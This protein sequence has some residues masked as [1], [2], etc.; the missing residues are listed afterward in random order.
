MFSP[1]AGLGGSIESAD[2]VNAPAV[3]AQSFTVR[4]EAARARAD[5]RSADM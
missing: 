2:T 4:A 3:P 1:G 5:R